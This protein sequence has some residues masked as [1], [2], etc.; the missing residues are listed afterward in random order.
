M[1]KRTWVCPCPV[2]KDG[3]IELVEEES[4]HLECTNP[5]CDTRRF[6][7]GDTDE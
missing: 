3:T 1:T 5:N 4:V 2:C 7:L 6:S